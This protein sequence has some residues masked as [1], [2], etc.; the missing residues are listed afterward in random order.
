[1][2]SAAMYEALDLCERGLVETVTFMESMEN[3]QPEENNLLIHLREVCG[4]QV[5]INGMVSSVRRRL[6]SALT[7]Y[8]DTQDD[9]TVGGHGETSA[10]GEQ[11]ADGALERGRNGSGP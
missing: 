2:P 4:L 1:M 7:I 8:P 5:T 6:T 9:G 3:I 11:A 10:G